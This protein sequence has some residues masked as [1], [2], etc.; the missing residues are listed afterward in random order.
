M[1]SERRGPW[2]QLPC[3]L[4]GSP[5]LLGQGSLPWPLRVRQRVGDALAPKLT[6]NSAVVGAAS[7]W[8]ATVSF[9]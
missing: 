3:L 2:S 6:P 7:V 1:K 9:S 5:V 4:E 8:A